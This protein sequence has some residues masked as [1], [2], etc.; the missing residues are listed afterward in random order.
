M[1]GVARS[2]ALSFL[3]VNLSPSCMNAL[4]P[5]PCWMM[6]SAL[7][8]ISSVLFFTF[9]RAAACFSN[10]YG[11]FSGVYVPSLLNLPGK[12]SSIAEPPCFVF[13]GVCLP[14]VDSIVL[15][16]LSYFANSLTAPSTTLNSFV[17]LLVSDSYGD[18]YV[19][20]KSGEGACE[21]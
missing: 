11:S 15:A 7:L 10:Q 12:L 14:A 9:A 4:I 18:T 1:Y 16:L 6:S 19:D 21:D 5:P 8:F 17:V 13:I 3:N 20:G 2:I